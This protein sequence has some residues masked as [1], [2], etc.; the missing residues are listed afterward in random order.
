MAYDRANEEEGGRSLVDDM[1]D[2]IVQLLESKGV[3]RSEPIVRCC[4]HVAR[5]LTLGR[6]SRGP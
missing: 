4:R 2:E 6:K 3:S 1:L 5:A